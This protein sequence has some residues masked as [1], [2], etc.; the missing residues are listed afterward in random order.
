VSAKGDPLIDRGL[1]AALPAG[2]GWPEQFIDRGSLLG[3]GRRRGE[4]DI[5]GLAGRRCRRDLEL[6]DPD[7]ARLE[8]RRS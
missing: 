6:L 4:L 5:H 7:G 3:R 8:L 1:D 2:V